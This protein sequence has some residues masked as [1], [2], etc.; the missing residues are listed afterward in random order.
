MQLN[1][2][3]HEVENILVC[4]RTTIKQPQTDDAGMFAL[5]MLMQKITTQAR[6]QQA[7]QE[8]APED[9]QPELE[10]KSVPMKRSDRR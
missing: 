1:L 10:K 2:E 5:M 4:I 9:P 7:P 6:A 8:D 3:P